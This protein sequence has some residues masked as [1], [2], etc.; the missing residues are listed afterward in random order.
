MVAI[1]LLGGLQLKLGLLDDTKG[2]C[3]N[4][5]IFDF[6]SDFLLKRKWK[7]LYSEYIIK[8]PWLTARRNK[9]ELPDGWIIPEFYVLEYPEWVNVIAITTAAPLLYGRWA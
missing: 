3:H 4:C 6:A 5:I 1:S 8:R 7:L 9:I 2:D